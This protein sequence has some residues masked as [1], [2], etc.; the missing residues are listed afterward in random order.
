MIRINLLPSGKKKA[1][2]IPHSV[3]YGAIATVL[4]II[5]AIVV[6]VFLNKE[7]SYLQADVAAKENRLKQL[8]VTLQKV[9]NYER[10]NAEFRKKSQIIE[11]LK[12]NQIIPL[13][14]LDEVSEMLP[15]GVWLTKLSD[16]GG[17]INI[18]GYAFSNTDLVGYVQSL[19][20]SKYLN[21]VSLIESRQMSLEQTTVYKFRLTFRISL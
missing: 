16:S 5:I 19:K 4:F 10:D 12:K 13:R 1:V 7:I 9:K 21:N 17:S 8:Q 15:K 6:L 11:Q 14:L 18:E 20:N 3:I 2:A